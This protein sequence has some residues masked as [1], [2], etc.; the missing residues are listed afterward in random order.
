MGAFEEIHVRTYLPLPILLAANAVSSL[1]AAQVVPHY[2]IRGETLV[3]GSIVAGAAARSTVT[4]INETWDELSAADKAAFRK[5]NYSRLPDTDEPPYPRNGLQALLKP[6]T[7]GEKKFAVTG[8]L[9]LIGVVDPS[10]KVLR[11][12][13]IGSPSPEMTKFASAVMML[14]PFKPGL[15]TGKPCAMEFPLYLRFDGL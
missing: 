13:A 10:G 4:P 5:G 8:T 1:A 3:P 7:L 15:C 6:I 2:T 9:E 11:V 12:T 14:T